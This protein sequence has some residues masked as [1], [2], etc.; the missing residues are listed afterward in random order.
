MD[1]EVHHGLNPLVPANIWLLH[2]LFLHHVNADAQEWADAWN[3]HHLRIKGQRERSPRDIYM[4][5]LLQDGPRG[6]QTLLAQP[7]EEDIGDPAAYGIDWDVAD[8]PAL[9]DH[10]L[11]SNPQD[12]VNSNPFSNAPA[13]FSEVICTPPRCPFTFNQVQDLDAQLQARVDVNSRNMQVRKLVWLEAL[14][15]CEQIHAAMP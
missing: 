1:L 13:E 4:F 15:I 3:S 2:H 11:E 6:I 7:V 10:L 12:W 8:D 9:M 5:S 14:A